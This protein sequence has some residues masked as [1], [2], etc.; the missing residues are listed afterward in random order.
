MDK[1]SNT[2]YY[3]CDQKPL[4][5]ARNHICRIFDIRQDDY[6]LFI[7]TDV[8]PQVDGLTK[9]LSHTGEFDIISGLYFEKHGCYGPVAYPD[10]TTGEDGHPIW[11]RLTKWDG[12]TIPVKGVGMGFCLIRRKVIK[13]LEP[14][15]FH[16]QLDPTEGAILPNESGYLNIG[17][18][19][20][21]CKKAIGAGFKIGLNTSCI[22]AHVGDTPVVGPKS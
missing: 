19:L 18:D 10:Y 11:H 1:P 20:Y 22:C 13:K 2:V 15:Y 3:P 16:W 8:I 7:D 9:L 4:H 12:A 14:P 6:L 5:A 17:E 21:F